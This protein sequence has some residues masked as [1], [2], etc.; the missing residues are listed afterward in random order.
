MED[1]I[2]MHGEIA[3]AQVTEVGEAAQMAEVGE[4]AEAGELGEATEAAEAAEAAEAEAGS[5]DVVAAVARGGE[6]ASSGEGWAASTARARS[7]EAGARVRRGLVPLMACLQTLHEEERK[8]VEVEATPEAARD[9]G[10]GGGGVASQGGGGAGGAG[11]SLEV[12]VNALAAAARR[13]APHSHPVGL[14]RCAVCGA[15]LASPLRMQAHLEG[16]KHCEAVARRHL[17]R[18]HGPRWHGGLPPPDAADAPPDAASADAVFLACST[19]ALWRCWAEPPDVALA[20]LQ[21]AMRDG[22]Q[23][24]QHEA[25]STGGS[26]T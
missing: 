14:R 9:G 5:S 15:A 8:A 25:L 10:G 3:A 16:R 20:V 4:A 6:A 2:E 19:A 12:W 1:E 23:E 18:P 24:V 13:A 7:G 26:L 22:E 17:H 11:G 21:S